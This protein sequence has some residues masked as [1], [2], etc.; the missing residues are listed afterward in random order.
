MLAKAKG[1]G[2]TVSNPVADNFERASLG[3][4][5]SVPLGNVAIVTSTDLGASSFSGVHI[6]QW[7]ATT[8]GDDQ[9]CEMTISP[10]I[11]PQISYQ[12][13]CRRRSSDVARYAFLYKDDPAFDYEG[14]PDGPPAWCFKYDGVPTAQ[15]RYFGNDSSQPPPQPG[16][17]LR[18]EVRGQNPVLLK[19]FCNGRLII[20]GQDTNAD[21]ILAGNAGAAYRADSGASLS[22]PTKVF[23]D[24]AA[25]TLLT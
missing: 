25:G 15:T 7:V 13:F 21:R 24:F 16:D 10:S 23:S 17:R 11:D 2:R 20:S 8:L 1:Y 9:F 5:W 22:Y 6:A 3:A 19:G 12:I 14:A 18:L 4:N